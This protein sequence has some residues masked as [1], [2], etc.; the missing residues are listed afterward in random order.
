MA[1][2]L[3]GKNSLKME[4]NISGGSVTFFYTLPTNKQRLAYQGASTER[5]GN[6][7]INKTAEA[8]QKYGLEI[9]T[10]V[11]AGDLEVQDGEEWVPLITDEGYA[12]YNPQWKDVVLEQASDLVE[13][14]AAHVF[15]VSARISPDQGEDA[16][17]N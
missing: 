13:L 8:R 3:G 16:E 9:L 7:I 11:K 17:K 14:L 12:G 4:D 1:R 6:R 15:D 10:G 5:K 2:R